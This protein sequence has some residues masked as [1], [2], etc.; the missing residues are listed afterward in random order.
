MLIGI[1][2][3]ATERM[4]KLLARSPFLKADLFSAAEI[5]YCDSRPQ[6][7][8]HYS[9]RWAAKEACL[10]A[11]GLR[12]LG[13]DWAQIEVVA[14]RSKPAL[15]IGCSQ[16]DADIRAVLGGDYRLQLSISHEDAASVAVVLAQPVTP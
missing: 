12:V 11:F 5:A 15:R 8:R 16:L 14:T 6:P 7:A 3:C 10:K 2:L 13:Y 9:G 1:D 4:A